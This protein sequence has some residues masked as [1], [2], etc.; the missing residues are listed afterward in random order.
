ML[1]H[2]PRS[3]TQK[4][5]GMKHLKLQFMLP[6]LFVVIFWFVVLFIFC[7]SAKAQV[8]V[9]MDVIAMIE[10]SGN[11]LAHNKRDD[12]RG[13]FQ[14]TKICLA[15]WNNFHP[16]QQFTMDDL[17][18][19]KVNRMIADWY[20]NVRIPAMLKYFGKPDTIENRIIAYNAGINYVAKDLEI[21]KITKNYIKKYYNGGQ[22]YEE[23]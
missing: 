6:Y 14:I 16:N 13:L 19:P 22:L 1:A 10:S 4:E 20:I 17:W 3:Q 9:D 12:S 7:N 2:P 18:Y 5:E 23:Q 8:V 15:E 21:P 11:P